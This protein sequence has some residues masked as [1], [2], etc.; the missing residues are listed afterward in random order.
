MRLQL[1][2]IRYSHSSPTVSSAE[3]VLVATLGVQQLVLPRGRC[4]GDAVTMKL[5]LNRSH[6][7]EQLS[8][9]EMSFSEQYARCIVTVEDIL[10]RFGS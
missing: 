4:F 3:E 5:I 8:H 7:P 2:M 1:L 10:G 6:E 9:W